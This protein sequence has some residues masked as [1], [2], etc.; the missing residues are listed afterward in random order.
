MMRILRTLETTL[1]QGFVW[2]TGLLLDVLAFA[3]RIV[4]TVR[5]TS[6]RGFGLWSLGRAKARYLRAHN[7]TLLYVSLRQ[8]RAS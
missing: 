1:V 8:T 4:S 2:C 6:N 7:F 5:L 3:E